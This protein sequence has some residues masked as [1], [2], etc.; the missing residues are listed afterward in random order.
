MSTRSTDVSMMQQCPGRWV[1]SNF[2]EADQ[3][4]AS[5]FMLGTQ[6]H[7]TIEV[8]INLD[9]DLDQALA[10]AS[11]G[12]DRQLE[13][14]PPGVQVVESSQRGL[15]TMRDDADR[16]MRQWFRTVHPDSDKRLEIYD[17]YEW[18]PQTEVPFMFSSDLAG[19]RY[20]VWGSVD[21]IFKA[22]DS[23][24][25]AL[26]D[27]KSGTSRQRTDDQLHYY[28]FGLST[29]EVQTAWFHH[30]DKQRKGSI[31]QEVGPWPGS[32]AIRQRI[33]AT[34]AIKDEVVAGKY[35]KFNPDWYC[36][37]CPVQQVCP[38]D[39][40]YRN[41]EENAANLRRMLKLARPMVEI[42]REVA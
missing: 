14:L 42:E 40:D 32:D 7:E 22:K 39:G 16:M 9:L 33:L 19:T 29:L 20:P 34:E 13:A 28:M 8:A 5:F 15:D 30:L 3:A 18:P 38:A 35:P 27:W 26:V 24:E 11:A 31:V 4:P 10:H 23:V 37:W 36:N 2:Y 41:R 25:H 21:A 1:L 17:E 6:L 12:I